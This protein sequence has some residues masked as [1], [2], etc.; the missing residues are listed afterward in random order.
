MRGAQEPGPHL[1][2]A[3]AVFVAINWG[4]AI[5]A[6][7]AL[8]CYLVALADAAFGRWPTQGRAPF[9]DQGTAA[10]EARL[11]VVSP[12]AAPTSTS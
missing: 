7:V 1:G 2:S 6:L 11:P 4:S 3:L 5:A 8:G 10:K 9:G 12:T